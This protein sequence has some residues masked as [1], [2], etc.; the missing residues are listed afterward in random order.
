MKNKG[1]KLTDRACNN[2]MSNTEY[3]REYRAKHDGK[4]LYSEEDMEKCEICGKLFIFL[5]VHVF[6][7]HKM[8]MADY[9]IEYGLD[10]K[11]GRTRGQ[12]RE[13]KRKRVFETRTVENLKAGKKYRFVPGDKTAG[14]YERSPE[15]K[16]R[17]KIQG[18]KIGKQFG[19]DKNG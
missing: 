12:F 16:A 11:R 6:R 1:V 13:L 14:K 9:K 19:G 17:L 10:R 3:Y 5:G 2:Y 18:L 8:Y 7:T 4:P 15:T